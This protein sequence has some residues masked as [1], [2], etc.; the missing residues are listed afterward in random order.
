MV[1]GQD[2]IL[3]GSCSSRKGK[4]QRNARSNRKRNLSLGR[5]RKVPKEQKTERK[6]KKENMARSRG[7]DGTKEEE[8]REPKA[9]I[10]ERNLKET[11]G[12]EKR[13]GDFSLP[14]FLFAT[15]NRGDW[16]GCLGEA[17]VMAWE[18]SEEA[19]RL[20]GEGGRKALPLRA[21]GGVL[22]SGRKKNIGLS[23]ERGVFARGK[24]PM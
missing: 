10:E 18:K 24:D 15:R 13:I 5:R 2:K 23:A 11:N 16:Y 12:M 17:L 19:P 22:P 14:S 6:K 8:G 4:D 21:K 3:G 7:F 20:R 9:N 1:K